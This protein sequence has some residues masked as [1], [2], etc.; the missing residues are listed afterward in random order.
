[1]HDGC[2]LNLFFF[3]IFLLEVKISMNDDPLTQSEAVETSFHI[4][5]VIGVYKHVLYF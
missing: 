2:V 1:M 4:N 5:H 3:V